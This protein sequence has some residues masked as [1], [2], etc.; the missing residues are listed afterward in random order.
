MHAFDEIHSILGKFPPD[1]TQPNHF[2]AYACALVAE[3]AYYQ[4]P[5]WEIDDDWKRAKRIPSLGHQLIRQLRRSI[6]ISDVPA[7]SDV[8]SIST[9]ETDQTISVVLKVGGKTF[10]GMRGTALFHDWFINLDAGR[11]GTHWHRGFYR[12]AQRVCELLKQMPD[13]HTSNEQVFLSG[14]S[15]GGAVAAASTVLLNH[16]PTTVSATYVFGS[17]RF[18]TGQLM[19][20]IENRRM[21]LFHIRRSGD[22]VPSVP[23]TSLGYENYR[24]EFDTYL[25]R[26]LR[27]GSGSLA[28]ELKQWYSFAKEK[29]EPHY[30][31]SYRSEAGVY[32][33]AAFR[34][35]AL[36]D[37]SKITRSNLRNVASQETPSK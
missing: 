21:P 2:V 36:T 15:L 14:H 22:M 8:Q 30:M 26:I 13:W 4:V 33:D 19:E 10:V 9:V 12:E 35:E 37:Y 28:L 32:A 24:N 25:K 18:G 7:I 11:K 34:N 5:Q 27:I 23:P 20:A 1:V 16:P 6:D 3:L 17:P 31:E 29:V